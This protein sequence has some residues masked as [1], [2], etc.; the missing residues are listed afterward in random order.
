MT[1]VK[2]TVAGF[3]AICH[4][5]DAA[6]GRAVN[7]GRGEDISIGELVETIGRR[8]GQTIV[9]DTDQDRIR[10]AASEVERLIAGTAL[11]QSLWGW[12]PR[13]TLELGLDETIAWVRDHLARVRVD[14][15]TT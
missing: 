2:D 8:L 9:V 10:P 4:G 14:A 11:A 12:K 6:V 1:Y 15:Y 13:F 7:I 5:C 3:V